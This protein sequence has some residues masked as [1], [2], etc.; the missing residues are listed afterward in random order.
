MSACSC[1]WRVSYHTHRHTLLNILLYSYFFWLLVNIYKQFNCLFVN[2]QLLKIFNYFP[3][4]FPESIMNLFV[5]KCCHY[6]RIFFNLLWKWYFYIFSVGFWSSSH[7]LNKSNLVF[8]LFKTVF[9]LVYFQNVW[10][11]WV[12]SYKFRYADTSNNWHSISFLI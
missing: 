6:L 10:V 2:W 3:T 5:S 7:P 4:M 9:L 12:S 1:L 8:L 11:I